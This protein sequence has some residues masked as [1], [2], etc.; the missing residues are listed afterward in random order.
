MPS[1]GRLPT[2]DQS[3]GATLPGVASSQKLVA[4][5]LEVT[6]AL[7]GGG[8][9]QTVAQIIADQL[10][11]VLLLETAGVYRWDAESS[12][13]RLL[14]AAGDVPLEAT[15]GLAR[16]QG[17]AG[18]CLELGQPVD[19]GDYA[20]WPGALPEA[21]ANGLGSLAVAP[22]I[23]LGRTFGVVAGA[24]TMPADWPAAELQILG[25]FA[26]LAGLALGRPA[27]EVPT[28]GT[29]LDTVTGL[30]GGS[31]LRDRLGQ[32]VLAAGREK[33]EFAVLALNIQGFRAINEEFGRGFG[34][35]V[36]AQ[37]GQR[38][39]SGLRASDTVART[40]AD[41]FVAILPGAGGAVPRGV[42]KKG[43]P[44]TIG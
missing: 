34:D 2:A 4:S 26:N 44:I 11:P 18:R 42:C 22:A 36:L 17:L 25:V 43:H 7:A 1:C 21:I 37:V 31:I 6:H 3:S 27:A 16:G 15:V 5:L 12:M 14:A 13:L 19:A 40:G 28:A 20:S 35:A 39:A 8:D 32:A 30:A 29:L 38:L 24:R 23:S 9:A 33:Q 10:R 41:L